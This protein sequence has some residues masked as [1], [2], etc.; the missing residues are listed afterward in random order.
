MLE[1]AALI[2][3]RFTVLIFLFSDDT[4][5]LSVWRVILQKVILNFVREWL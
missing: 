3:Q 4:V 2:H 1:F 5:Q